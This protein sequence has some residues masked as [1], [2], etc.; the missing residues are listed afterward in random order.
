MDRVVAV[1]AD[2]TVPVVTFIL[3]ENAMHPYVPGTKMEIQ[4]CD[5]GIV[6]FSDRA[7]TAVLKAWRLWRR[8]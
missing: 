7:L 3:M 6:L 5:N 1:A 4:L 8:L 2:R